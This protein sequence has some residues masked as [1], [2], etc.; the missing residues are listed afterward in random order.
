MLLLQKGKEG[1]EH[2]LWWVALQTASQVAIPA[3]GLLIL[4]ISATSAPLEAAFPVLGD[5]TCHL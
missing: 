5:E 2:P 4:P 3:A 1:C